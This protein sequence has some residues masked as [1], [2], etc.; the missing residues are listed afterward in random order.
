MVELIFLSGDFMPSCYDCKQ[1][2]SVV[3]CNC[4]DAE[5]NYR[6]VLIDTSER[7]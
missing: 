7:C 1:S 6:E 3:T 4:L 5:Q 2:G